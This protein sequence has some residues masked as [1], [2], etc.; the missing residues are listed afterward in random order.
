MIRPDLF[1]C[2]SPTTRNS[3][4]S[5]GAAPSGRRLPLLLPWRQL[6]SIFDLACHSLLLWAV[7]PSVKRANTLQLHARPLYKESFP[8]DK[9]ILDKPALTLQCNLMAIGLVG[10]PTGTH[11]VRWLL[12]SAGGGRQLWPSPI[13][14]Q[15]FSHQLGCHCWY[16]SGTQKR[17]HYLKRSGTPEIQLA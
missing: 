11:Y 8:D 9:I 2:Q 1:S 16:S 5:R 12:C 13:H 17:V 3:R 6:D 7:Q 14:H 15:E 10:G 4:A